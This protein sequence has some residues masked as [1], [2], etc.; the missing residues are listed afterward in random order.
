M[1][2]ESTDATLPPIYQLS[3]PHGAITDGS[4]GGYVVISGWILMCFFVVCVSTRLATRYSYVMAG[5]ID[6]ILIG[7]A[8]LFGIAQTAVIHRSASNGLGQ[9]QDALSEASYDIYAKSYYH[10]NILFVA[11]LLFSKMSTIFLLTRLAPKPKIRRTCQAVGALF[12]IWALGSILGLALQCQLPRPWDYR[13]TETHQCSVNAA[14]LNYSVMVFDILTDIAC[15][16]IPITMLWNLQMAVQ[17]R[18]SLIGAFGCRIAVCI[19]SAIRI[20]ALVTYFQ[21][22]DKSWEAVSPQTWAQVVQC[23][24]IISAC[25][26][27]L[28]VFLGSLDS[29]FMDISMR[30]HGGPTYRT[31]YGYGSK[32]GTPEN[33]ANASKYTNGNSFALASLTK[34]VKANGT[35]NRGALGSTSVDS[36]DRPSSFAES[37]T[38]LRQQ[39]PDI[40]ASQTDERITVTREIRVHEVHSHE[41][42]GHR[43]EHTGSAQFHYGA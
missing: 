22:S 42:Q 26:P 33:S 13:Q 17:R 24:S 41:G 37:T 2:T 3:P 18:W 15:I 5:G 39:S 9:H 25:I 4:H 34:E 19:C 12:T 43:D 30:I 10:G 35:T 21:T 14:A 27:S 20:S 31:D 38:H 29:G 40:E 7:I 11:A 6:D 16:V 28:K 8:M 36:T 1:S 32:H 23:L